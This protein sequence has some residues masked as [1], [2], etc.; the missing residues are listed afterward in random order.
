MV[1]VSLWKE[2]SLVFKEDEPEEWPAMACPAQHHQV[3]TGSGS[4]GRQ[5]SEWLSQAFS[6]VHR[7]EPGTAR[8]QSHCSASRSQCLGL[9]SQPPVQGHG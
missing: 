1:A 5:A 3:L 6:E 4:P 9:S 2:G 7:S 8:L